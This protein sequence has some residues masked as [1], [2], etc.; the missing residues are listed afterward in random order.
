MQAIHVCNVQQEEAHMFTKEVTTRSVV[1]VIDGDTPANGAYYSI[2]PYSK[3]SV[4]L[5]IGARYCDA[6]AAMFSKTGIE[7]LIRELTKLA[8]AMDDT[9]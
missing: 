8:A 1:E 7:E 9:E 6:C 3:A 4:R 5:V 2:V